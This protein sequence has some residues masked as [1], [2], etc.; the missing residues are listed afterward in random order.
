LEYDS[1]KGGED[2][3]KTNHI[4]DDIGDE[5]RYGLQDML[6]LARKPYDVDLAERIA[7][8]KD[9]FQQHFMRLAE[10]ERRQRANKPRPYW[11]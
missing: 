3:L 10:T 9:P 1:D 4:Y 5:L 6:N 8:A 7:A 11:E 2:I